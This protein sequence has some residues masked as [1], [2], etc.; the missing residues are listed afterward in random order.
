MVARAVVGVPTVLCLWISKIIASLPGRC[1]V[2]VLELLTGYGLSSEISQLR[3]RRLRAAMR[4][5]CALMPSAEFQ[6]RTYCI[7]EIRRNQ[8]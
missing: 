2:T 1:A 5:R 3:W 4:P 7:A 8:R 6:M